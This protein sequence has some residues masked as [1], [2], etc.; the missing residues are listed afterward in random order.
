[1]WCR[2]AS[3][4][5]LSTPWPL[6]RRSVSTCVLVSCNA[7]LTWWLH[8]L[9]TASHR[10]LEISTFFLRI[11]DSENLDFGWNLQVRCSSPTR[12]PGPYPTLIQ[13][14]FITQSSQCRA[15]WGIYSCC[16]WRLVAERTEP[17]QLCLDTIA[18]LYFNLLLFR[19][20]FLF[21]H[22][23][24]FV[25]VFCLFINVILFLDRHGEYNWLY[26][27]IILYLLQ[28]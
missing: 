4:I 13:S 27:S 22:H 16:S 3:V 2:A 9:S 21:R 20:H 11:S 8:H 5:R 7:G 14:T 19:K 25:L 15:S 6:I 28:G 18:L 24:L 10:R 26:I 12:R 17:Y 23:F 1:M